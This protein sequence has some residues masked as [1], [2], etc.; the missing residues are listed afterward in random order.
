MKILLFK[1]V[2]SPHFLEIKTIWLDFDGVRGLVIFREGISTLNIRSTLQ[3]P[4]DFILLFV[5]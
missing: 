3:E 5:L 2:V 4:F 1:P